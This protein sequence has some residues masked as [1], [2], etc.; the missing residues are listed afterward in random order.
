MATT[1]KPKRTFTPSKVPTTADLQDGEMGINVPDGK[2]YVRQ[3]SNIVLVGEVNAAG[4]GTVTSVAAGNGLNFTTITSSGSVT[5]GTPGTLSGS[6]TNAVQAN[7]HTHEL[8]AN[9]SAWDGI[10]PDD[11][12]DYST[13]VAQGLYTTGSV[14]PTGGD[15][16]TD[17]G[18]SYPRFGR[19]T[20]SSTNAPF[21][22]GVYIQ[23]PYSTDGGA[24]LAMSTTTEGMAWKSHGGAW[25]TI[26]HSGNFANG[27]TAQYIRGD[28]S[29]ATFPTVGS[30][31]VTSVAAGNGLNFTTI[32]GSGIVTLGTPGTING[33]TSNSVSTNS[34][35][36]SL[37][38]TTDYTWTG[39]HNF[40]SGLTTNSSSAQQIVIT[41]ASAA[42]N[43]DIQF[44]SSNSTM[45]IGLRT[46]N[47]FGIGPNA[48][49]STNPWMYVGSDGLTV[50]SGTVSDIDGDVRKM[51]G[52][53]SNAATT[54]ASTDLNSVVEKSNNTAYTYTIA[55]SLGTVRDAITIVNSGTAGNIT[56]ARGTGVTLYRN[57]VN[58]N[59][60]VGPGS[61]VTIYRSNTTNRWIA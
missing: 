42:T 30:G 9:L 19:I 54:L 61:M 44:S 1:I 5:L 40:N 55:P 43:V 36:H 34:H 56:I 59:I 24:I 57:G 53:V 3:G 15:M 58:A 6:T 27:T 41:R 16:D 13:A 51:K 7:S 35:T 11:K 49:L 47:S 39:L 23:S 4:A 2:T 48:N 32:T 22:W 18:T 50:S 46:A 45:Y 29:L 38:T 20:N 12:F 10:T 60:V 37:D 26:Y 21:T 28:G 31:T 52:R 25:R 8:S 14:P 33:S 17:F